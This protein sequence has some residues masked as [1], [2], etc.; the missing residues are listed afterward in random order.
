MH[1][2][3]GLHTPEAGVLGVRDPRHVLHGA[4]EVFDGELLT[5]GGAL[6]AVLELTHACESEAKRVASTRYVLFRSVH[7][8]FG[9]FGETLFYLALESP[10]LLVEGSSFLALSK[11]DPL[12]VQ[13]RH[14][15]VTRRKGYVL[16]VYVVQYVVGGA[17]RHAVVR[18]SPPQYGFTVL[19]GQNRVSRVYSALLVEMDQ[20]RQVVYRI[21]SGSTVRPDGFQDALI[22]L[23]QWREAVRRF[24]AISVEELRVLR[25]VFL[26]ES[27]GGVEHHGF[28]D[29]KCAS[30]YGGGV[31]D[32]AI[33]EIV[34]RVHDRHQQAVASKGDSL[35]VLYLN[36]HLEIRMRL[37]LRGVA[38]GDLA[39]RVDQGLG[40]VRQ[41]GD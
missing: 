15:S 17:G 38:A 20:A 41:R 26:H 30:L 1:D 28:F 23:R 14:E 9:L 10:L 29:H 34:A 8:A 6:V 35:L 22:L 31:D 5:V 21:R 16:D 27:H 37:H 36:L 39:R 4:E 33:F 13:V 19:K 18:S 3:V 12:V 7:R 32:G 40:W 2:E 24:C 25:Q 11:G